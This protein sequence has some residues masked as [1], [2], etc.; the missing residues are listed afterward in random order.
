MQIKEDWDIRLRFFSSKLRKSIS[1][2]IIKWNSLRILIDSTHYMLM[3][4]IITFKV[5]SN[6][7]DS[8]QNC[9]INFFLYVLFVLLISSLLQ[10]LY[11][12]NITLFK[13]QHQLLKLKEK[14]HV[15]ELR[16]GNTWS[17]FTPSYKVLI[18]N[19]RNF[20][21]ALDSIAIVYFDLFSKF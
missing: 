11:K 5:F 18:W 6:W 14:Q 17:S 21:Q 15:S 7:Y 1:W 9:S 16:H 4:S 13:T 10:G 12:N 2:V 19:K 8:R 3:L 20:A